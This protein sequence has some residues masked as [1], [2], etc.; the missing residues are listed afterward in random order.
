MLSF[1]LCGVRRIAHWPA[2]LV[3]LT[4]YAVFAGLLM[5]LLVKLPG[6]PV[7]AT[8]PLDLAFSY[9]VDTV[10][11]HGESL[12]AAGRE[13]SAWVHLTLD[14]GYP[15]VYSLLFAVIMVMALRY[16]ALSEVWQRRT[17][18]LP[19]LPF[20]LMGFDFLENFG[21]SY[22]MLA[23]PNL[24]KLMVQLTSFATSAKWSLVGLVLSLVLGLL[25]LALVKRLFA[26]PI[27]G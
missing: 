10:F 22:L 6:A 2:L 20:L 21:I 18:Y 27:A 25:V 9:S 17:K 12:G 11:A 5:R 1:L 16:L 15:I 8:P 3:L 14:I 4:M 19:L 26:K 13:L 23:W 7:D 24:P